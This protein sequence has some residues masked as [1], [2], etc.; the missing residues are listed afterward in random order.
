[1]IAS[2]TARPRPTPG[3]ADSRSPRVNFSKMR[4]SAPGATPGP[5]SATAT[6]SSPSWTAACRRRVLPAGVYFAAFSS[7]LHSTRSISTPSHSTRGRS[8]RLS[9]ATRCAASGSR[10]SA[11]AVPTSSSM[12]CH[13]RRSGVSRLCSRAMSSRLTT[14]AC[15]RWAW[16]RMA[17][18]VSCRPGGNAACWRIRVSV[19]PTRLVSGVRRSCDT[20]A[21]SELRSFSDSMLTR[22]CCATST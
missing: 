10:R 12:D 9:T 19:M 22:A 16:S 1:M 3:V 13:S 20:A 21:S 4:R 8:D 5:L 6:R 17:C 2:Q 18:R 14:S 15:M 7:R 11:S